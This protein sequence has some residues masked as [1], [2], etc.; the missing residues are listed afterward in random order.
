MDWSGLTPSGCS[1]LLHSALLPIHI[2]GAQAPVQCHPVSHLY[3]LLR[4]PLGTEQYQSH[5]GNKEVSRKHEHP[6]RQSFGFIGQGLPGVRL[7]IAWLEC[8]WSGQQEW[9]LSGAN[10]CC[11]RDRFE[12]ENQL[13]LEQNQRCLF[14]SD[15]VMEWLDIRL[16][17]I[18]VAVVTAIAGI[19]IIQHQKQ[20]GNP[21]RLPGIDLCPLLGCGR[22]VPPLPA[23]SYTFSYT[24]VGSRAPTPCP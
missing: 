14:A 11:V 16:Q 23:Q 5:A 24:G 1:L 3:P 21:G 20:L 17:M 12:L 22:G 19:A 6:E 8:P 9:N 15:T 10:L 13:R 2:P 18:G 4:D 7:V